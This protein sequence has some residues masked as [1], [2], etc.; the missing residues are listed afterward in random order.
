MLNGPRIES[1]RVVVTAAQPRGAWRLDGVELVV[2]AVPAQTLREGLRQW[3]PLIPKDAIVVSL[4]KGI[5]LGTTRRMSEVIAE[6][7]GIEP[8][9]IVVVSGPNLAKEI[10][11]RK[12]TGSVIASTNAEVRETVQQALSCTYFRVYANQDIFGV[13]L[14]GALKNIYA[15]ATGMA[16][17][18][19]LGYAATVRA[20]L[21]CL[22]A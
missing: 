18:L 16:D 9:R 5:E 7:G 11:G 1:A 8:G 20:Y 2:I 17:A 15:I 6:A 4:M 10:A 21:D 12:L 3:A 19:E 14:A 13:E 22:Q